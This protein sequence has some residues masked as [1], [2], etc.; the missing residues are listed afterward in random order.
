MGIFAMQY[1]IKTHDIEIITGT[2][3][4]SSYMIYT[5]IYIIIIIRVKG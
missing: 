5:V 4:N 1:C 2:L 3:Q